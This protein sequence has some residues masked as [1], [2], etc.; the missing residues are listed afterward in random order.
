[1]NE[2]TNLKI[3]VLS[4]LSFSLDMMCFDS[5]SVKAGQSCACI[6]YGV[7]GEVFAVLL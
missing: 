5:C 1:M 3:I 7:Q 6:L 4:K 2:W